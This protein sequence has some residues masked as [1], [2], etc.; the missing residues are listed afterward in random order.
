VKDGSASRL[1]CTLLRGLR[2]RNGASDLLCR[3]DSGGVVPHVDIKRRVHH[4]VRVLSCRMLHHSDLIAEFG[5]VA[6]ASTQV[7]A[8]SPMMMRPN[9]RCRGWP[10]K[11]SIW[12]RSRPFTACSE[13]GSGPAMLMPVF[14][15]RNCSFSTEF[16]FQSHLALGYT[17][18]LHEEHDIALRIEHFSNAGIRDPNPGMDLASVRYAYRF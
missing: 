7:C 4:F 9:Q 3:D 12:P 15:S 14:R 5:R 17:P 8:I 16:N 2:E 13:I 11:A 18:G 10:I 1:R 6:L